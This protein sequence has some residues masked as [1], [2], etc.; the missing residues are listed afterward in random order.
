MTEVIVTTPRFSLVTA[1]ILIFFVLLKTDTFAVTMQAPAGSGTPAA[2]YQIAS[3]AH[4][5]WMAQHPDQ[6]GKSF[7]QTA[8]IDASETGF[9]DDADDN[10]DGDRYNDSND[11]NASGNN[12][13]FSP[14]GDSTHPFYGVYNGGRHTI[15]GLIINRPGSIEVG[16]WRVIWGGSVTNTNLTNVYISGDEAVGGLVGNLLGEGLVQNCSVGGT[17]TGDESV[18]GVAGFNFWSSHIKNCRSSTVVIGRERVG[19]IVGSNISN[20][21]VEHC[22]S[23]AYVWGEID[24]GGLVGYNEASITDSQ[25]TGDVRSSTT[26]AGG[27]V[28][29]NQNSSRP[30]DDPAFIKGCYSTAEVIGTSIVGGLVGMNSKSATIS[31][32]YTACNTTASGAYAGGLVGMNASAVINTCFSKGEVKGLNHVGG[33]VG[34]NGASLVKDCYSTANVTRTAGSTSTSLGGFCGSSIESAILNCYS[35][36]SVLYEGTFPPSDKGFVGFIS[37][38]ANTV[39]NNFWDQQASNQTTNLA[40]GA[41]GKQTDDMKQVETFTDETT[42]GLSSA[43]DFRGNPHDDDR[44]DDIWMMGAKNNGYPFFTWQVSTGILPCLPALLLQ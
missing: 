3:L 11:A 29:I 1:F 37:G 2:P 13:G 20:S 42:S 26:N 27:L 35:T 32:S 39:T 31:E 19:G 5:S 8:D 38:I 21:A 36:G 43:W 44:N 17:V 33:L 22:T 6:W 12:E 18:G 40:G 4:L 16:P 25:C 10:S 15:D 28:G 24:V 34:N 23:D 14:I 30:S 41:T 7:V 9:W